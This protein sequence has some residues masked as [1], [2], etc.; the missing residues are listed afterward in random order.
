MWERPEWLLAIK[1][2]FQRAIKI[3]FSKVR[4]KVLNLLPNDIRDYLELP[5]KRIS[6][7][8][9]EIHLKIKDMPFIY[10]GLK[11]DVLNDFVTV[12]IQPLDL[13]T[14][15]FKPAHYGTLKDYGVR[16]LGERLQI[17]KKVLF[18]GSA[19]IGKT[20][21][22][23]HTIL[24]IINNRA[25]SE[26]I[27]PRED[28]VP[29]FV[30]LK[31]V[32]NYNNYPILRYLLESNTLL[33]NGQGLKTLIRLAQQDRLFL[34][35]DGYDEVQLTGGKI[36]VNYVQE[37]IN[38]MMASKVTFPHTVIEATD[39]LRSFYESLDNCRIW[40][41]SRKEFFAFY[42]IQVQPVLTDKKPRLFALELHGIGENRI[43]LI[44]NIFRQYKNNEE[45]AHLFSEKY[46]LNQIDESEDQELG[47]ISYNPLFLT[48]MCYTYATRVADER[49]YSIKVARN[50]Y[51]LVTVC[52]KLLL[53]DLDKY[54]TRGLPEPEREAIHSVRNAYIP[55]KNAFLSY[56]AGQLICETKNVF[57]LEYINTKIRDFFGTH[58]SANKDEILRN[59]DN[60][61]TLKPNFSL[62]LI[63]VGVF[64]RVDKQGDKVLYDFPHRRFR[65]VLAS[66]Y[67]NTHGYDFLLD[68][69]QQGELSELLYVFLKMDNSQDAIL[70]S[71]LKYVINHQDTEYFEK[72]LI[73][74]L[75]K[76][77]ANYNPT[78]VLQDCF[79]G[80]IDSNAA[81]SLPIEVLDKF[82]PDEVFI[83]FLGNKFKD[84]LM[85]GKTSSLSLCCFLLLRHN[86][87]LMRELIISYLK[88]S[89]EDGTV[90][91]LHILLR[92]PE[93][94]DFIKSQGGHQEFARSFFK[95][96][97]AYKNLNSVNAGFPYA[98]GGEAEH[99][100]I[101]TDETIKYTKIFIN[102]MELNRYNEII[103]IED[104]KNRVFFSK[105]FLE[106]ETLR[107]DRLVKR[108]VA[109]LSML[110]YE[111]Y[112]KIMS[113][114]AEFN[115]QTSERAIFF[116]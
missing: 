109:R 54:K 4:L 96:K 67:F 36:G 7:H 84:C 100:F 69:L 87:A 6:A 76:V 44:R 102:G 101:I 115:Q 35:L 70:M 10:K 55:D 8:L 86:K 89:L 56:F 32:D 3:I 52:I 17:S 66:E 19:G 103:D 42:P 83:E 25:N 53:E 51:E 98:K 21:F 99:C 20:T 73:D 2:G 40:L 9:Q 80:C 39:D 77:P 43:N 33:S 30:P 47:E 78:R 26:Y 60:D 91:S 46:F 71:I 49:D 48:M 92:F 113:N 111:T 88:P 64:V 41:S 65:E 93:I 75:R 37:E 104:L 34:F 63:L 110:D 79:S 14:L 57:D 81:F 72:L 90:I 112:F 106:K 15:K 58:Y 114:I 29:F 107:L 12:E 16:T 27:L 28:V 13:K 59:L 24:T 45:I 95:L 94:N 82:R 18:L 97:D 31:A 50:F 22:Q 68:N 116:K 11:E 62:Q 74:C 38:L 5:P 105:D 61:S 85:D 23:R 1:I 108:I